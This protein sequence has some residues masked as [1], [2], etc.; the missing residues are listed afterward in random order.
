MALNQKRE[1]Q[2]RFDMEVKEILSRIYIRVE[3]Y[4]ILLVQTQAFIQSNDSL[5]TKKFKDYIDSIE[6]LNRYPGIQGLGYSKKVLE[7]EIKK[8]EQQMRSEGFHEYTVWPK[9]PYRSEYFPITFLEP[10]DWRNKRAIGFDMFSEHTRKQSM[11]KAQD[12]GRAV[13]SDKVT[14]VQ[15]TE[16]NSQPGFLIYVPVFKKGTINQTKEERSRNIIGFV[17]ATFRAYD[18]FSTIFQGQRLFTD[19]KIYDNE[20]F[21]DKSLLYDHEQI[22]SHHISPSWKRFHIHQEL[23]IAGNSYFIAFTSEDYFD[24]KILLIV[25]LAGTAF[26]LLIWWIV[27]SN[28][29]ASINLQKINEELVKE[30]VKYAAIFEKS[31]TAI[32]ILRGKDLIYEMVNPAYMQFIGDREM[33]GMKVREA[34]PELANQPYFD[35]LDRVF[36]NGEVISLKNAPFEF[37]S[38]EGKT[39]IKYADF[40]YQRIEEHGKPYGIFVQAVDTTDK[41]LIIQSIKEN[42]KKIQAYIESMP[43]MAFIADEKGNLTYFNQR[44]Y[45]Y[46]GMPQGEGKNWSWTKQSIHHPDDLQKTIDV[47]SHAIQTGVPYEIEYRLR[48]YDG[49]YRWHL[50]RAV[51]IRD[52]HGRIKEWFGTNTD[53]HDQKEAME[54]L[55]ESESLLKFA[56]HAGEMGTWTI[57]L[58]TDE[59]NLSEETR[60]LFGISSPEKIDIKAMNQELLHADDRE[61]AFLDLNKAI[62]NQS[63]YS[64]EYRII[65]PSDKEQRWILS[66]GRV[67]VDA[68]GKADIFSGVIIDITKRK[69]IEI[70]L[71]EKSAFLQTILEQMPLGAFLSEI[72][73][74]KILFTN[75]KFRELWEASVP[76]SI[77][78]IEGKRHYTAFHPDGRPY[79]LEDW[80]LSRVMR[81]GEV[82][83]G[84]EADYVFY[85]KIRKTFRFSATPIRNAKGE[86]VAGVILSEDVTERK[87]INQALAEIQR[88]LEKEYQKIETVFSD[89]PA[90]M[91]ILRGPDLIF[92]KINPTYKEI[93]PLHDFIGKKLSEAVPEIED[94]YYSYLME[95]VFN[96]G[97][98]FYGKE[99]LIRYYRNKIGKLEDVYFDFTFSRIIDG[100]GK[101][102]GIY[103][104]AMDVTDKVLTRKR[105]EDLSDELQL[106]LRARDEFLSIASHELKTP[107]TSLNLQ[108]EMFKR[109][110]NRNDPR[111]YEPLIVNEMSEQT[112]KQVLR[113]TKLVDDMFDIAR[114]RSGKLVIE[115]EEFDFCEIIKET[116]E[117]MRALFTSSY[118]DF[119][120]VSQCEKILGRWDKMRIEQVATNLFTNAIRYGKG[121]KIRVEIKDMKSFVRLAVIDQGMGIAKK[122][123]AKIFDR[124]ERAVNASE[125][126][127]LGLGLYIAKQIVI[128][129]G[130]SIR[131]ESEVNKGTTFIVDL[132][133]D[134][135][136]ND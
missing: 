109:R 111:I 54:K 127:G 136:Q 24:F 80:P 59:V 119:P 41:V 16:K 30:R 133:K 99:A 39:E 110:K 42:E 20:T 14:L 34:L 11:Q 5:T 55:K 92:E 2:I 76:D 101:P 135:T 68:Y 87:K 50:A 86:I 53:I 115:K 95:K 84:E 21:S 103:I 43:Q 88:N 37:I 131:V 97:E 15:E 78:A 82:I 29:N 22:T 49:V 12:T 33:I 96:T 45:D 48:R 107:L 25:G 105:L 83:V 26:T 100:E 122:D 90:A 94:N 72:P 9:W 63:L 129:H 114:I 19:F 57:D 70:Q 79:E 81:K 71:E 17:H 60:H 128:S 74:G 36:R 56:L 91:A 61:K 38:K 13:I 67:R 10:M 118:Y 64:S 69:N 117:R 31:P 130:G 58:N 65:R 132:P 121:K 62:S 18:L 98:T 3:K 108:A 35:F 123:Q 93:F 116:L 23:K 47:W 89:S 27:I 6:I 102:Y 124:F 112:N 51:A 44:H 52:S 1:N 7:K 113:L 77:Q 40:V 106:S 32:A 8:Y 46:F 73:S 134:Y 126:S 104:H 66:I 85:E 125:V 75:K 120:E 28:K 4:E